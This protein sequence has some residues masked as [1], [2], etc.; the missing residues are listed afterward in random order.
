MRRGTYSIVARDPRTGELGVAAQSH[1]L[2]VGNVVSFAEAG[3]GV[4]ATQSFAERAYGPRALDLLRD[5]G[6]P[7]EALD[8]LTAADPDAAVRQ[9]AIVDAAGRVAVHTGSACVAEAGDRTGTGYSCQA[10]M[11]LRPTVPDAMAAAYEA[12]A[13]ALAERL[14]AALDAAEAEGG[15]I[16]G[17]QSATLL[18]VGAEGERWERLLDLRV[19]DHP[20]PLA[21]LRRLF[22][23]QR[24][25][26]LSDEAE[27]LVLAGRYEDAA[28]LFEQVAAMAP[29]S[30]ELMFW[31]GL[32]AA[33]SGDMGVAR[34]R[35]RA[36]IAINPRWG[37][38]LGRLDLELFPAADELRDALAEH[39]RS[40]SD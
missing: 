37:E 3:V 39:E 36:A 8:R 31:S 38:L 27:N 35:V 19:D 6:A 5:G 14:L 24:A 34:D 2:A 17:S 9:V 10:S 18:V 21:E 22:S 15:D 13:G 16:R 1:W 25:Y 33:Q 7:R 26:N 4:V 12:S 11:M 29:G 20:E 23:L 40:R 28:R 30:D 32:A